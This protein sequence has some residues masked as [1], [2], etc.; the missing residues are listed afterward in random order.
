M[1]NRRW[2]TGQVLKGGI[3]NKE[4]PQSKLPDG[5]K[6]E[7]VDELDTTEA[8]LRK[9]LESGGLRAS[10]YYGCWKIW[11]TERGYSG[12]LLQYRSVTDEFSDVTLAD[13]LEKA[14]E[15]ASGCDG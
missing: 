1:D 13:A 8:T 10:M 12:E 14:S 11:R 3:L 7:S 5:A 2:N 15:W 4:P 9:G 6:L